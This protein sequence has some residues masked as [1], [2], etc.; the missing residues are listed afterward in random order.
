MKMSTKA[1]VLGGLLAAMA[2]GLKFSSFTLID[3]R[4]TFYDIPL[5]ISSIVLG[6]V[7]GGFVGFVTDWVYSIL[8]G[9][10][11][12]LF[13]ISS[14]IWGLIPGMLLIVL[15]RVN[16]RTL[17]IIILVTSVLAFTANTFA[18]YIM[19]GSGTLA[20]LPARI[21]TMMIKLPIQ[22]FAV[23]V[24]YS[25]VLLPLKIKKGI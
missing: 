9:Y 12:G 4:L 23:K 18:L 25:R 5:I 8:M 24:I 20:N 2:V 13:T 3:Y 16:V 7:V 10:P 11:I 15:R 14:I 22:V 17:I 21:L 1:I 19:Y 6:P